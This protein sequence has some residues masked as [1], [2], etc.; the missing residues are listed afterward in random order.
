MPRDLKQSH[1]DK[2][3]WLQLCKDNSV[4]EYDNPR[5]PLLSLPYGERYCQYCN[6]H[7]FVWDLDFWENQ[8]PCPNCHEMHDAVGIDIFET[9]LEIS[10]MYVGVV[11]VTGEEGSGKSMFMAMVSYW[12]R[13]FFG[14]S[15]G[16]EVLSNIPLKEP[17]GPYKKINE[18]ILA[19]E[20][21]RVNLLADK[22]EWDIKD[23]RRCALH[24]SV[25]N[26]DEIHDWLY[27]RRG[28][29]NTGIMLGKLVKL[30]RHFD[31]CLMGGAPNPQELDEKL[32]IKRITHDVECARGT[33][34]KTSFA[35]VYNRRL[36]KTTNYFTMNHAEWGQLFVS[37]NPHPVMMEKLEVRV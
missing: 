36:G 3:Y 37:K 27:N 29:S 30:H 21:G 11:S 18:K 7:W 25:T 13:R 24:R 15:L 32:W 35:R 23:I 31:I 22:A 26:I 1:L 5:G 12:M 2:M 28:M 9:A 16:R 4:P 33:D 8:E 34:G 10:H 17:F 6:H 14:E 19:R 20:L